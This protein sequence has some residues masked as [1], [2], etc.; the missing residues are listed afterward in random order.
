MATILKAQNFAIPAALF[1]VTGCAVQPNEITKSD[2]GI[3]SLPEN[4]ITMADPDQDLSTAR[5]RPED[6]CFWYE[7]KGPVETTLVPL[8]SPQGNPICATPSS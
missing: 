1:L 2:K 8:R 4:V 7:H 3:G 6:N 5:L